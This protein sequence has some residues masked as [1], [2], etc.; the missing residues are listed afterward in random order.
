[1]HLAQNR[2]QWPDLVKSIMRLCVP[3]KTQHSFVRR[4]SIGFSKYFA[5][6]NSKADAGLRVL[7]AE[8]L[9]IQC[10]RDSTP[11]ERYS[12]FVPAALGATQLPIQ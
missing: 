11:F 2:N 4:M 9:K 5:L 3:R 8:L 10:F 1:M 12:D 7:V 6:R